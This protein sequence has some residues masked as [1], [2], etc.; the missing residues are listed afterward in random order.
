MN[1]TFNFIL[2]FN[3]W[4]FCFSDENFFDSQTTPR[5][6]IINESDEAGPAQRE[7]CQNFLQVNIGKSFKG[8]KKESMEDLLKKN[9]EWKN[10][11]FKV[12][13]KVAMIKEEEEEAEE[14]S[15]ILDVEIR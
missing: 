7:F 5:E 11:K 2:I 1:W 3:N 9:S 13:M 8:K 4:V 10:W 6:T 15:Q 12:E 14:H